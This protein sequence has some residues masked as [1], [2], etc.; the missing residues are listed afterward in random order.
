MLVVEKEAPG[1]IRFDP[2]AA[3]SG[4][5]NRP[6]EQAVA[7]TRTAWNSGNTNNY[8]GY[9]KGNTSGKGR[10]NTSGKGKGNT[11][12]KGKGNTSGK[13]GKINP[14]RVPVGGGGGMPDFTS[15]GSNVKNAAAEVGGFAMSRGRGG[16]DLQKGGKNH[17]RGRGQYS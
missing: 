3:G 4:E 6:N 12:G 1:M 7:A 8:G 10:G 14:N 13:G 15:M 5:G 11:S 16:K 2:A 9:G 17:T